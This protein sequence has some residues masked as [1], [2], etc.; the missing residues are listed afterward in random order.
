[1][2][3]ASGNE[4]IVWYGGFLFAAI[5]FSAKLVTRYAG[6]QLM[7]KPFAILILKKLISALLRRRHS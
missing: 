4:W 6:I 1:M 7:D 5:V 2:Y 3:L